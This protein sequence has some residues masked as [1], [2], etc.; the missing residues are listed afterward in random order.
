FAEPLVLAAPGGARGGGAVVTRQGRDVTLAFRS[1]E[2]AMRRMLEGLTHEASGADASPA[3]LLWT[4][5]MKVSARNVLAGIVVEVIDGAV[6]AEVVLEVGSAARIVAIV[7]R[8]SVQDLGLAPGVAAMA[9]IDASFIILARG[10][11]P[12]R[13]SA[14]NR[15]VGEVTQHRQGAVNDE[16]TLAIGEGKTLTAIV[17]SQSAR[18]LGLKIGEPATALIK[19]SHVILAVG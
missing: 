6:N 13:T 10:D 14:R 8:R 4:L 1:M 17:T 2:A 3:S 18:D 15:L 7:T 16:V 5:G 19:A 12:V 9:L 11:E